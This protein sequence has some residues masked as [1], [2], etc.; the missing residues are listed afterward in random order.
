MP[1]GGTTL[2]DQNRVGATPALPDGS[3]PTYDS[4]PLPGMPGGDPPFAPFGWGPDIGGD[5][6]YP[7][8]HTKR[9]RKGV[10]VGLLVLCS[11]LVAGLIAFAALRGDNSPNSA[12]GPISVAIV[13]PDC[14]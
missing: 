11:V 6:E 3:I 7:L 4:H 9:R 14:S 2:P 10:V 1:R 12:P 13:L 5:E 8:S